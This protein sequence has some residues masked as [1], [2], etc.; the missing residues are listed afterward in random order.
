MEFASA[1]SLLQVCELRISLPNLVRSWPRLARAVSAMAAIT[2]F[3]S[4]AP[5]VAMAPLKGD[6]MLDGCDCEFF[7]RSISRLDLP[8][9]GRARGSGAVRRRWARVRRE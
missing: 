8:W 6:R 2:M 4:L 9:R 3:S 7:F 5:G 1:L